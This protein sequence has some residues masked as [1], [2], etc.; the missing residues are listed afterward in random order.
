MPAS[1]VDLLGAVLGRRPSGIIVR[2][3]QPKADSVVTHK[4]VC[5]ACR[6]SRSKVFWYAFTHDS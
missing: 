2:S 4:A 5:R 6:L 3:S 1:S